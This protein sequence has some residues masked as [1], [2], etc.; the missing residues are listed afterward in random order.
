MTGRPPAA[1][2]PVD[3]DP[4]LLTAAEAIVARAPEPTQ[5]QRDELR[6][7][8]RPDTLKQRAS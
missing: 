7:I 8:W 4:D 3:A 6:R 5:R 2:L 1:T